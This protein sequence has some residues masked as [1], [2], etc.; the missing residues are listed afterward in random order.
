[1]ALDLAPVVGRVVRVGAETR[2]LLA[3]TGTVI[4]V[5]PTPTAD[6]ACA[7][8]TDDRAVMFEGDP[9]A[10]MTFGLGTATLWQ[11]RPDGCPTATDV[12]AIAE[13]AWEPLVQLEPT[14]NT[15]RGVLALSGSA[16]PIVVALTTEGAT[17]SHGT[18]AHEVAFPA[19]RCA[20]TAQAEKVDRGGGVTWLHVAYTIDQNFDFAS[21]EEAREYMNDDM[22]ASGSTW[23]EIAADGHLRTIAKVETPPPHRDL[24]GSRWHTFD[25]AGGAVEYDEESVHQ[26]LR[27]GPEVSYT[28]TWTLVIG[29]TRVVLSEGAQ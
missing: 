28:W 14:V 5:A 16:D 6:S 2:L 10:A 25:V 29:A 12:F 17:V 9:G 13:P 27:E 20:I 15:A 7:S 3:E 8:P 18:S 26:L 21:C 1:M 4:A 22:R 23:F 19:D 11:S 24:S